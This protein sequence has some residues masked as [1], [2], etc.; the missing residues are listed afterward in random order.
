MARA[1]RTFTGEV[2]PD[3]GDYNN[4]LTEGFY[5]VIFGH[6]SDGLLDRIGFGPEY[7]TDVGGT[8]YTV[9]AHIRFEAEIALG[10]ALVV[11]TVVLGADAKRLH[12][13]HE[14]RVEGSEVRRATQE[15]LMLHVDI[16]PVKVSAMS[17]PLAAAAAS[18]AAGH[19][20][21]SGSVSSGRPI[22]GLV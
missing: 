16:D 20:E 22:R 21:L 6:A 13:W 11:D 4:H 10:E 15:G 19:A 8:F 17:P 3:W 18:L 5:G 14:L 9:E 1:L 7:R 12:Y 2:S